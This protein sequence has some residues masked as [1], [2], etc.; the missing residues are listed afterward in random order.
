MIDIIELAKNSTLGDHL[1]FNDSGERAA[2]HDFAA[3]YKQA[4]IDSGELVEA[5]KVE[6]ER[7]EC[8]KVCDEYRATDWVSEYPHAITA[9]VN[10][11]N[12]IRSRS[13]K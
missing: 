9:A 11:A 12:S 6:A 7:E 3:R 10:I 1:W 13:A 4:L 2:I 5:E 8:A